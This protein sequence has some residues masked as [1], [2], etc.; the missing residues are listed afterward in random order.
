M[1]RSANE[2]CVLIA[3][4]FACVLFF[5]TSAIPEILITIVALLAVEAVFLAVFRWWTGVSDE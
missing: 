3:V 1:W 4:S 2:W 5:G